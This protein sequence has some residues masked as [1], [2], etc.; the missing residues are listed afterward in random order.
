MPY[1]KAE[2]VQCLTLVSG[3]L[4]RLL[5]EVAPPEKYM[6]YARRGSEENYLAPE[7]QAW[8]RCV[9]VCM[10]ACVCVRVCVHV[11]ACVC[12]CTRVR[13]SISVRCLP[14]V[15]SPVGRCT[16]PQ[17]R[18]HSLAA[19]A[20]WELWCARQG[21]CLGP[22]PQTAAAPAPIAAPLREVV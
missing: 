4:S 21:T 11:C 22:L 5:E 6:M 1:D 14:L 7:T 9:C 17:Q 16:C 2:P 13:M 8:L 20:P 3:P 19:A 15:S 12:V 18:G 10:C